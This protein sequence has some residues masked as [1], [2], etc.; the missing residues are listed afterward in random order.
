VGKPYVQKS[1]KTS[2]VREAFQTGKKDW[3]ARKERRRPQGGT[4][5]IAGLPGPQGGWSKGEPQEGGGKLERRNI[6]LSRYGRG[7]PRH[8]PRKK[9]L[10]YQRGVPRERVYEQERAVKKDQEG[11]KGRDKC[12]GEEQNSTEELGAK[13][14]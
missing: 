12:P 14:A 13:E 6:S 3:A 7:Y 11:C 9:S 8:V 5:E 10:S 1:Q 2:P 4:L